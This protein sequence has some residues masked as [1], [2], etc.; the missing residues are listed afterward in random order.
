MM[1]DQILEPVIT[2]YQDD[3]IWGDVKKDE[4]ICEPYIT[5]Y[6]DDEMWS[7]M[8]YENQI[9]PNIKMMKYYEI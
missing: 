7:L 3:E 2:R 9:K 5:R 8:K 4:Q 6:K 1:H